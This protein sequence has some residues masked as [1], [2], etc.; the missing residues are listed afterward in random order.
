MAVQFQLSFVWNRKPPT[1]KMSE[2]LLT[3]RVLFFLIGG[4]GF[5]VQLFFL[6]AGNGTFSSP[7]V[8]GIWLSGLTG[9]RFGL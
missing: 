9:K 1:L 7:Y 3:V 5:V 4:I 2:Q 8:S 6:N